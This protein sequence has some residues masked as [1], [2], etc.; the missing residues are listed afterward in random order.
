MGVVPDFGTKVDGWEGGG[1]VY[2]HVVEDVGA[3]G[4]NKVK[5]VCLKIWESRDISE[6]VSFYKFLLR[7]PK[8]LSM[9]V[10]D[11]VLMRVAVFHIS[12]GG[13]GEEIWEKVS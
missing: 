3:E 11:R 10:N 13:G 8:F 4:S 6:E 5:G 2:P 9:V 12:A 1:G 7:D